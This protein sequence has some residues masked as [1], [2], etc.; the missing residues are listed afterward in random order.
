VW[1]A[2]DAEEQR[3]AEGDGKTELVLV[4]SSSAF[5]RVLSGKDALEVP[6]LLPSSDDSVA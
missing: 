5:L 1:T 4:L 6:S 2:E 3:Y